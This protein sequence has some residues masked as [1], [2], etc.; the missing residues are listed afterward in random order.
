MSVTAS[1]RFVSLTINV[2]NQDRYFRQTLMLYQSCY[3]KYTLYRSSAV[4]FF[5][6]H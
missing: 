1:W 3:V 6:I 2:S 4:L 5:V